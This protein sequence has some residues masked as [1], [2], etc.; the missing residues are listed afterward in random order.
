MLAFIFS[1]VVF[2][3]ICNTHSSENAILIFIA[4]KTKHMKYKTFIS[5]QHDNIGKL[6][7]SHNQS[8]TVTMGTNIDTAYFELS[9]FIIPIFDGFSDPNCSLS[10]SCCFHLSSPAM[11]IR[12]EFLSLSS[13]WSHSDCDTCLRNQHMGLVH[14]WDF[15]WLPGWFSLGSPERATQ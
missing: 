11:K 12:T 1:L 10:T 8:V 4:G 6:Q 5:G 13:Y 7:M 9:A 14:W 2:S 15:R 3:K